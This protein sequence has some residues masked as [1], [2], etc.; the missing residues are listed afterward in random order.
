MVKLMALNWENKR[1]EILFRKEN[2]HLT[3]PVPLYSK[4]IFKC[5]ITLSVP[6]CFLRHQQPLKKF[7]FGALSWD[8]N[9]QTKKPMY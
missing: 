3:P 8:S 7:G 9:K 2:S 5:R 4:L 6:N 1:S